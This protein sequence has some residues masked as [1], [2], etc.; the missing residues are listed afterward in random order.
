MINTRKLL[1]MLLFSFVLISSISVICAADSDAS[2]VQAV[3]G[4]NVE[5]EQDDSN[6]IDVQG[7]D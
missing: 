1:I 5:L 7:V 2:D 4:E 3:G 6:T